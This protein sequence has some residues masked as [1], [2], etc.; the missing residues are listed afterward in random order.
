MKTIIL[1]ESKYGYT[2]ECAIKIKDRVENSDLFD[3][4]SGE[5][6]LKEYDTILIGSPIIKGEF[7]KEIITFLK[8]YHSVLMNKKVGIFCSGMDKKEFNL[9]VQN[10]MPAELFY[11]AKIIH[12]GGEINMSKLSFRDRR[13]IKKRLNIIDSI[14]IDNEKP[15][16]DFIK[17][18]NSN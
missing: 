11:S 6:N 17:W 2:K 13:T 4:K 1:Y 8:Q 15:Y 9:A 5:F 14:R 18:I 3:V 16:E 12:C 7:V 10:S